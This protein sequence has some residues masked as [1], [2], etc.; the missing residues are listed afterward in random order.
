M[1]SSPALSTS[2]EPLF[3]ST[4]PRSDTEGAGPAAAIASSAQPT[5]PFV[6]PTSI[7]ASEARFAIHARSS[8]GGSRS[9]TLSASSTA[10]L[11]ASGFSVSHL[12]RARYRSALAREASSP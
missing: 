6:S 8:P 11:W 3:T 10:S 2:V 5:A 12:S 9:T 1:S 7:A 4:A